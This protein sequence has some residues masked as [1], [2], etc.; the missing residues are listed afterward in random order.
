M[1]PPEWWT[2]EL[3]AFD[4]DLR[5]RWSPKV[6][7]W[8]IERRVRRSLALGTIKEDPNDDDVVRARD[9]FLHVASLP[10]RGF[11]R[12]ALEKLKAADLWT[13]GGW[14]KIDRELCEAEA[15]LE[16]KQWKDFD[17]DLHHMHREVYRF[18]SHREGRSCFSGG[19]PGISEGQ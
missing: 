10:P 15:A 5:T 16:E 8:M 17:Q 11:S 14:E 2:R 19:F 18:L 3:R 9:G 1:K 13:Q 4:P 7:L 6:E 12:Y